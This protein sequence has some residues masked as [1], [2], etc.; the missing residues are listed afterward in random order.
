[1]KDFTGFDV[2]KGLPVGDFRTQVTKVLLVDGPN[3]GDV[4]HIGGIYSSSGLVVLD[5][6]EP[7]CIAYPQKLGDLNEVIKVNT[8]HRIPLHPYAR[9]CG[10][11]A[12]FAFSHS[13][14]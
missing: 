9:E 12:L 3:Q 8:Y 1:M 5:P 10:F 2:V 4:F 11:D 14:K 13:N 7:R 6:E